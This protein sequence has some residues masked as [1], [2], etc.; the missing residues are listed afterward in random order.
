MSNLP[1]F[2]APTV[3]EITLKMGVIVSEDHGQWQVEVRDALTGTLLALHSKPHFD[4]SMLSPE[5][6]R[7]MLQLRDMIRTAIDGGGGSGVTAT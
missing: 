6:A 4:L 1:G 3:L 5:T 2:P 7:A